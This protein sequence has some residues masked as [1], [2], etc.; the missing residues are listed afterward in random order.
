M[1]H[2][3]F[4]LICLVLPIAG[5]AADN[6]FAQPSASE[7]RTAINVMRADS[8]FPQ[9]ARIVAMSLAEPAKRDVYDST[10]RAT[11][12]REMHC[13]VFDASS[14]H[15][16]EFT[17]DVT[18]RIV[19]E[20]RAIPSAQ[21]MLTKADY[22]AADSIVRKNPR[23]V[24]AIKR[25]GLNPDSVSV[26]TWA[27]GTPL[28]STQRILRAIF[29]V[30]D[31]SGLNRYDRPIEGL[32]ATISLQ[33]KTVTEWRDREIAPIPRATSTYAI[34]YER[35]DVPKVT[36]ASNVRV[37]DNEVQWG[38]WRFTPVINAREG[39][40]LYE[41]R[42][43]DSG[44]VRRVAHRVSLSEMLVPYGDTSGLWAWRNAFDVGEYGFGQ[45]STQ[46]RKGA[47]VP[48][49]AILRSASFADDDGNV[50]T[51]PDVLAVYERDAGIAWRHAASA[52]SVASQ[53][54]QDLVIQH[55]AVIGNYD[56]IISYV[57]APDGAITIDVGLTGIMLVKGSVDTAYDG[58]GSGGQMYAHI[59]APNVL[60]PSHQHF[61]NFRLDLDIED[62]A[63]VVTEVDV[64]SPPPGEE[65]RFN[66]AMM[67]DE[68]DLRSEREGARDVSLQRARTWRVSSSKLNALG[69]PTA[70]TIVPQTV[71]VPFLGPTALVRQRARFIEHQLYATR[72]NAQEFYAAGDYPNESDKDHG[73]P[74]YQANDDRLIRRDV[75]LW[76]TMGVTHVARP[77]DWPVMPTSHA[78]MKI[79][80]TGFFTRNPLLDSRTAQPPPKKKEKKKSR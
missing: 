47:D 3:L 12:P 79:I 16:Y 37:V 58:S 48:E 39:L 30:P 6:P 21:P 73:L 71:T 50:V 32:A 54:G 7:L 18:S 9:R 15:T 13:T 23:F 17:I 63:N 41:L 34:P 20:V 57:L 24:D 45:N 60:A 75:V 77:E 53:R 26:E 36:S 49:N 22:D 62:T 46:L 42:F 28:A 64:W 2:I 68:W 40:T 56:Y 14:N 27:S 25:R 52:T 44:R 78:T 76:Y 69:A 72:Y 59:V 70:Y 43:V 11:I 38:N 35:S 10:K 74:M 80:P 19:S 66:N 5:N 51:K 65:N 8:R 33:S 31:A 1:K 67:L 29:Y 55:A 4:A 61:F